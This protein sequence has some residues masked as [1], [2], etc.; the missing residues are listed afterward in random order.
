MR[1]NATLN[2]SGIPTPLVVVEDLYRLVAHEW[3]HLATYFTRD[4]NAIEWALQRGS[5]AHDNEVEHLRQAMRDMFF[6]RRRM[7]YYCSLIKYHVD[8]ALIQGRPVWCTPHNATDAQRSASRQAAANLHK[9]LCSLQDTMS[10]L[11]SRLQ[12]TMSH[13]TAETTVMEAERTRVQNK[14]LLVLAVIGTIFL[15]VSSIASI[16]SMGGTWAVGEQH[17]GF[18]W[19]ICGPIEV[20]L[21]GLLLGVSYWDVYYPSSR[22]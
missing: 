5:G 11:H 21:L 12:S 9:D 8:S 7:S 22:H 6:S 20:V 15:P 4:L 10:Q 1:Q 18:F 16:F 14:I 19:A 13:V 17:F 2:S 3:A